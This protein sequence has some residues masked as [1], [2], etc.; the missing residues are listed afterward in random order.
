MIY[1]K[2]DWQSSRDLRAMVAFPDRY[3][4]PTDRELRLLLCACCRDVWSMMESPCCEAIETAEQFA[5]GAVANKVLRHLRDRLAEC[6]ERLEGWRAEDVPDMVERFEDFGFGF[7]EPSL[8]A[9][10]LASWRAIATPFPGQ[11]LDYTLGHLTDVVDYDRRDW[12]TIRQVDLIR[13]VFNPFHTAMDLDQFGNN[14]RVATLASAAYIHREMPEG[15]LAEDRLA[16]LADMLEEEG[17]RDLDL[18]SHLRDR[19]IDH[20][21][22]CWAVDLLLHNE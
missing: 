22:G 12:Q 15:T 8:M 10:C 5:D 3:A 20:V 7:D 4:S 16:V 17:C 14:D 19:S 1:E 2:A 21:R 11:W 18:V 6:F 13:D 9:A